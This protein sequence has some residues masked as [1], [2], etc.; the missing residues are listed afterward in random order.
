[1]KCDILLDGVGGQG[2]LSVA[3][4][5]LAAAEKAGLEAVQSEVHGM[6]QRGGAVIAHLRLSDEPIHGGTISRGH[7]HLVIS[8]EPMEGLRYL[9]YL[10]PDGVLLTAS[11][12]VR[13][14]PDYPDL[15]S[16]LAKVREVPGSLLVDAVRL[17]KQA[18]NARAANVV[19]VGA[20]MHLLPFQPVHVE[21]VLHE[22][23]GRKGEKVV[24]ANLDAFVAGREAASLQHA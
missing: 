3:G 19:M 18:G 6:S 17:A 2:V 8:M 15:D 16:I 13:N 5:I 10:R 4:V 11:E 9:D 20:A 21:A 23:F 14:I 12:P 24:Q 1:M 7:A 22:V